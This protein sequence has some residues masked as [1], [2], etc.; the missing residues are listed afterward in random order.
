MCLIESIQYLNYEFKWLDFFAH[1]LYWAALL[2][3]PPFTGFQ[4]LLRVLSVRIPLG[5][6]SYTFKSLVLDSSLLIFNCSTDMII[7]IMCNCHSN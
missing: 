2:F 6:L 7:I 3:S 4:L 5:P 1:G